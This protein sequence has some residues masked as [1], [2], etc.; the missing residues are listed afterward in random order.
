MWPSSILHFPFLCLDNGQPVEQ[1]KTLFTL[2]V[3]TDQ[4]ETSATLKE[5]G[6]T[7]SGFPNVGA[8]LR[9]GEEGVGERGAKVELDVP[10]PSWYRHLLLA[11]P[12]CYLL[13]RS[14]AG[15]F[16]SVPLVSGS[17]NRMVNMAVVGI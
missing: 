14:C 11:P 13:S 4:R 2:I 17:L 8:S 10:L 6:G 9:V 7:R 5:Q 16:G 15:R 3:R 12:G 1:K